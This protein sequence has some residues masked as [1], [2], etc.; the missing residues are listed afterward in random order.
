MSLAYFS[1][2]MKENFSEKE[3]PTKSQYLLNGLHK[4]YVKY[5][6]LVI[7]ATTV[8]Y[9]NKQLKNNNFKKI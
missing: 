1:G 3:E 2:K 8:L 4:Y 7:I 6:F 5:L 9:Y